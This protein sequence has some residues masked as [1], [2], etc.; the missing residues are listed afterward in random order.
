MVDGMMMEVVAGKDSC[1]GAGGSIRA[2]GLGGA[3][4]R[5]GLPPHPPARSLLVFSPS[6]GS[7]PSKS[8]AFRYLDIFVD[9]VSDV[10]KRRYLHEK[11][12][13]WTSVLSRSPGS[14]VLP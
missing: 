12:R 5:L 14:D 6:R 3:A 8:L 2:E 7:E 1:Q 10:K 13:K 4:T 11:S 9:K